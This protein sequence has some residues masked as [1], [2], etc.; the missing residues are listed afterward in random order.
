MLIS[1]TLHTNEHDAFAFP[2]LSAFAGQ[3]VT[4]DKQLRKR[5][6]LHK[7]H[8]INKELEKSEEGGF[9]DQVKS[10]KATQDKSINQQA[11]LNL[12]G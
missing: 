2:G 5:E 11:E 6:L 4:S 8:P 7:T 3:L 12:L 1:L 10:S 9:P